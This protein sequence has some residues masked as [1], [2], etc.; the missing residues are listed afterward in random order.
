MDQRGVG[1]RALETSGLGWVGSGALK[2]RPE[3]VRDGVDRRSAMYF[4]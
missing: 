1:D 3:Q 2:Q 4:L